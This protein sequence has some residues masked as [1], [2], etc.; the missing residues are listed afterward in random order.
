[1]VDGGVIA[2]EKR[3]SIEDGTVVLAATAT[4]RQTAIIIIEEG[5]MA[6]VHLLRHHNRVSLD[7][8]FIARV[9]LLMLKS[10]L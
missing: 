2:L 7:E 9:C 6:E 5:L 8:N 10:L 4:T 3:M 1:V